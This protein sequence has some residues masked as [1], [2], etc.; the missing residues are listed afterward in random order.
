MTAGVRR[1]SGFTLLEMLLAVS[2][3]AI[4][5]VVTYMGF[6][7]VALAW[8]RGTD[9][10]DKLHHADFVV[11]QIV[12][13]LRS[14]YYP[15]TGVSPDYGFWFHDDGDGPGS[16][17]EA[18][19]V[20]LGSALVGRDAPQSGGPHRVAVTVE[21]TDRGK[22][23]LAVRSWGVLSQIEGFDATALEPTLI[24]AKITGLNYRFQDP[25]SVKGQ[26]GDVGAAGA[27]AGYDEVEWIDEWEDTNRI[28]RMVELTVYMEPLLDDNEPV[29]VKRVV[30]LPLAPLAW[31]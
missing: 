21:E 25:E 30:E 19:W 23:A 31:R 12:M 28:P 18:S 16:V 29:E 15:S 8:Q 20:K 26:P 27:G 1:R 9:M 2:L 14:S 17:D 7:T 5:T 3:L 13:S 11:E 6:S 24:A 10:A 22:L 4:V